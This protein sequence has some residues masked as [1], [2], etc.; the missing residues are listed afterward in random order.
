MGICVGH[1]YH[2]AFWSKLTTSQG[3]N[4]DKEVNVARNFKFSTWAPLVD[5]QRHQTWKFD[6]LSLVG[7]L[8]WSVIASLVILVLLGFGLR[9]NQLGASGFAEDEMNK[10]DAVRAFQRIHEV[11]ID[12]ATAVEVFVNHQPQ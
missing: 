9:V 2:K 8:E 11:K 10:L 3:T 7:S 6:R 12:G 5:V 4:V 1:Y